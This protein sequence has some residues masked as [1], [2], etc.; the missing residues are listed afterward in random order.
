MEWLENGSSS[1]FYEQQQQQPQQRRVSDNSLPLSPLSVFLSLSLSLVLSHTLDALQQFW[2]PARGVLR[3][4]LRDV[5]VAT[6]R[7]RAALFTD[8]VHT[9]QLAEVVVG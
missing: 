1:N 7:P 9:L 6:R 5:V 2:Q 8:A 3:Y 4:R